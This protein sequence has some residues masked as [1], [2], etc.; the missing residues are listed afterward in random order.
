[1][2]DIIGLDDVSSSEPSVLKTGGRR[3]Y[4]MKNK[5]KGLKN[6]CWKGYEAIGFKMKNGKKVPNCVKKKK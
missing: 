5:S 3:K 1:M 4:N 2:D 6:A